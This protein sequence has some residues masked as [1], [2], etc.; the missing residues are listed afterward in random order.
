MI[1]GKLYRFRSQKANL[2]TQDGNDVIGHIKANDII[3]YLEEQELKPYDI[4]PLHQVLHEN[5]VL[6]WTYT[7]FWEWEPVTSETL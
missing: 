7:R 4:I 5:G 2:F 1:K 3:L 6:G